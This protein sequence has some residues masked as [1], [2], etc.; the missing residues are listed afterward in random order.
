M[1][2]ERA[3]SQAER[4]ELLAPAFAP[5]LCE[6]WIYSMDGDTLRYE[7]RIDFRIASSQDELVRYFRSFCATNEDEGWAVCLMLDGK[8]VVRL[9]GRE[10]VDPWRG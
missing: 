7:R 10:G 2:G 8:P 3:Q 5:V 9:S 4:R 1:L 6:T